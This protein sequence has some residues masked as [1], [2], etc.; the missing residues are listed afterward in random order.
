MIERRHGSPRSS[1][2]QTS[3]KV[4]ITF[5]LPTHLASW[6]RKTAADNGVSL[7][8]VVV[9][10]LEDLRTWFAAQKPV[11]GLLEEDRSNLGDSTREYLQRLLLRR[12]DELRQSEKAS[13][14]PTA[15]K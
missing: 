10:S 14:A 7:N 11:A 13:R 4:V 8:E 12:Y 5:R 6:L 2:E 15:K 3:E 9:T 1:D